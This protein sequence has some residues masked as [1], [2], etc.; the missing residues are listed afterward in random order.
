MS[1]LNLRLPPFAAAYELADRQNP[2]S[3]MST[4]SVIL[5]VTVAVPESV[6]SVALKNSRALAS[7]TTPLVIVALAM[8]LGFPSAATNEYVIVPVCVATATT[9]VFNNT[10][11]P[12]G[13]RSAEHEIPLEE[14][15]SL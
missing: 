12:I 4:A 7:V 10:R 11:Y 1:Y 15:S 6:P 13:Y 2:V 14:L 8:L 5:N 9:G 3:V